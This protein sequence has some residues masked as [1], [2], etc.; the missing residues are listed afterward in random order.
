MLHNVYH[1]VMI[2]NTLSP[3]LK[4]PYME[5]LITYKPR[6]IFTLASLG[7]NAQN[8]RSFII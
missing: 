3:D 1:S 2:R 6:R 7:R 5:P 8:S 4:K